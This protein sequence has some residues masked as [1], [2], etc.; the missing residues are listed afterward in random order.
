MVL[1]ELVHSTLDEGTF[2]P[3]HE[4]PSKRVSSLGLVRSSDWATQIKLDG[5]FPSQYA[6]EYPKE[7]DL[8]ETILMYAAMRYYPERLH[9]I[10]PDAIRR[11]MPNR[12]A[13]LDQLFDQIEGEKS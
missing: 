9:P 11:F 7:E 3:D 5:T 2:R 10:T 1:H 6:E 12:V 8:A 4:N 13:L